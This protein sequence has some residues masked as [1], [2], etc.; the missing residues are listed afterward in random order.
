MI[1]QEQ[2]RGAAET[3]YKALQELYSSQ[4]R[5]PIN[6]MQMKDMFD[7]PILCLDSDNF[8]QTI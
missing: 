6:H 8:I 3:I 7:K 2:T 5:Y 1:L 4:I